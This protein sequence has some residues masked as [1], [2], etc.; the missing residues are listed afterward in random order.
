MWQYQRQMSLTPRPM[1]LLFKGIKVSINAEGWLVSDLT[2]DLEKVLK[3]SPTAWSFISKEA[4]ATPEEVKE[5]AVE[6]KQP[7]RTRSVKK[8]EVKPV[9]LEPSDMIKDKEEV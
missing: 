6:T 7:Q 9:D 8:Q 5:E 3:A 4:E 2:P 1:Q